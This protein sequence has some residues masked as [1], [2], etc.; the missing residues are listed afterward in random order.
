VASFPGGLDDYGI[1]IDSFSPRNLLMNNDLRKNGLFGIWVASDENRLVRNIASDNGSHGL[2]SES[3]RR[4]P[5]ATSGDQTQA[6]PAAASIS[7]TPN[8]HL[9]R[10]NILR[11]NTGG[12]SAAPAHR[13]STPGKHLLIHPV[14]GLRRLLPR[15]IAAARRQA[16]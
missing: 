12:A 7:P 15:A 6:T 2:T 8:S 1:R 4:G 16:S 9:Y 11:T 3:P 10:N 5:Q 14:G 13:S